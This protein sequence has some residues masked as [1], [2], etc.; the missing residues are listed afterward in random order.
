M[1]ISS[2]TVSNYRSL[3]DVTVDFNSYYTAICGKNDAGKTNLVRSIQTM[4]RNPDRYGYLFSGDISAKNEYPAWKIEADSD[5]KPDL[6]IEINLEISR[7]S[8]S[9]LHKFV[10][11]FTKIKESPDVLNMLVGYRAQ[12]K[13]TSGEYYS[14]VNDV[15]Q[16]TFV[17]KQ[18]IDKIRSSNTISFY[19]SAELDDYTQQHFRRVYGSNFAEGLSN[20]DNEKF[21][22]I[23]T[24]LS[25]FVGEIAKRQQKELSHLLGKLEDKYRVSINTPPVNLDYLPFDINLGGTNSSVPLADWGSG[26]R[27]RTQIL[28]ALF[29]AKRII[30]SDNDD[31]KVTP[32]II[33]EEPESFLHP[34]AQAEFGR[35]LQDLADEFSV[36]VICTTHS[37]YMLSMRSPQSNILLRRDKSGSQLRGTVVADTSGESWMEPFGL[38]LGID[39]AEFGPWRDLLFSSDRSLLLVEGTTDLEYFQMLRDDF[40]QDN[41]LDFDGDIYPYG[42]V[43]NLKN[44]VLLRFLKSRYNK[45]FVTFDLD[46]K[47]K[48]SSTL[49]QLN[50][51]FKKDYLPIG[52]DKPGMRDIEG[53]VPMSV[54]S[55][56]YS[57]HPEI[58]ALSNSG[59]NEEKNSGRNKLKQLILDQFKAEAKPGDE[60]F[61]DFYKTVKTINKSF[62]D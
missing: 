21:A 24:R 23:Q 9:S 1:R 39:N 30:D 37:P 25:N 43:D 61:G 35:V 55:K 59:V 26:T 31:D 20:E 56:V 14:A 29:R 10:S 19:N 15:P 49:S 12:H 60:Y 57:A 54:R 41:K 16:D 27:N 62:S 32:I 52:I 46:A 6:C 33:I 47:V 36:Q 5:A 22:R 38:A 34:S 3:E 51:D 50:L 2:V 11:T 28:L 13:S 4:F 58:V 18:L 8:D 53:L 17:T 7:S 42:G 45:F 40:H 48:L 44:N